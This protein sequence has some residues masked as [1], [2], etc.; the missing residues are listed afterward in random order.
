MIKL[1]EQ[2]FQTLKDSDGVLIVLK[3]DLNKELVVLIPSK[4]EN[5]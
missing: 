2:I 5:T 4:F 3:T 1:K